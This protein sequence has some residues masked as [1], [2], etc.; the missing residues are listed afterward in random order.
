MHSNRDSFSMEDAMR[1]ANSPAGQQLIA[2]LKS[3][4][5]SSVEQA[6]QAA[7]KGDY[8][9]TKA[10]LSRLLQS[11]DVQKLLKEMEKGNG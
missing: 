3:A 5:G 11:Q 4:G 10:N 9:T 6:R 7:Q 8:E 1:L 2:L